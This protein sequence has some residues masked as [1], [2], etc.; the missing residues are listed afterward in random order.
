MLLITLLLVGIVAIVAA[1]L[2]E[3][4]SEGLSGVLLFS[5]G[6]LDA[7]AVVEPAEPAKSEPRPARKP[8]A[9]RRR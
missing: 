1:C 3:S 8:R 2:L 7:E 4:F 9:K 6:A 5:G